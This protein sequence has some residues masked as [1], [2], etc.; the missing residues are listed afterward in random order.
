VGDGFDRNCVLSITRQRFSYVKKT[1]IKEREILVQDQYFLHEQYVD[2]KIS[3]LPGINF[4]G[5]SLPVDF[6]WEIREWIGK[7]M[8]GNVILDLRRSE[9]D[10]A[11]LIVV[12]GLGYYMCYAIF[13][14]ERD[15]ILFKM[16]WL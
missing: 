13:E 4:I 7:Q 11:D 9:L 5:P 2:V 1:P 16:F 6:K 12:Q 10:S 3:N 8:K 14:N 15:A